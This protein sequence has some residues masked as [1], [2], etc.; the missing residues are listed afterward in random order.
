MELIEIAKEVLPKTLYPNEFELIEVRLRETWLILSFKTFDPLLP[1]N[2]KTLNIYEFIN[3][4]HL[5]A[6]QRGYK[7]ITELRSYGV[8][9]SIISS[10]ESIFDNAEIIDNYWEN[11]I[12]NAMLDATSRIIKGFE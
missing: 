12:I 1:I 9:W 6:L 2:I 4:C 5:Y 8:E 11:N 7:I 3:L 10:D